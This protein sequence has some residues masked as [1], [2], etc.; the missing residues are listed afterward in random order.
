[1]TEIFSTVGQ[2]IKT[3]AGG[4]ALAAVIISGFFGLVIRL[5]NNRGELD[6]SKV[7]ASVALN[8]QGNDLILRMVEEQ[9][10]ELQWLRKRDEERDREFQ[11]HINR[12]EQLCD[13]LIA[14]LSAS[15]DAMRTLEIARAKRYLVRIGKLEN[16]K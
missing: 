4:W 16:G 13:H 14:I 5:A 10:A 2:F 11:G 7:N 6:V 12:S 9:K 1:M 3:G 15:T 8:Q